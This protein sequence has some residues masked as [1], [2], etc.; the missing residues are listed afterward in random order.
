MLVALVL[1]ADVAERERDG[2]TLPPG[3]PRTVSGLRL[4][5]R[6]PLSLM[7]TRPGNLRLP[8]S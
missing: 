3:L 6:C 7:G 2:F 8:R 1:V 4:G 5:G